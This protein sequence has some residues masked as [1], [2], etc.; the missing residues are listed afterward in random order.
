[1][2]ASP[3]SSD[4]PGRAAL[5]RDLADFLIELSIAL[6][7]HA[8]YP[9][10]HP[11]LAPAAAGVTRRAALLL[12][13][14]STLSLGV[15]RRQLVIEGIATDPK[16]PVLGELAERLHRHH[17]GA[18][19]FRKG[20]EPAE[21][22]DVLKTLAVD[23]ERAGQPLGLGNPERLRAW[24]HV[25]LHSLTYERLE[26]VGEGA[27]AE[28]AR[29]A[30]L[31]VGLARAA[32]ALQPEDDQPMATEPTV[33]A[34]AIDAHE[35]GATAY[36]QVIV[37]YLLQI[38]EELKTAGSAEAMALRRRMS[39]LVRSLKPQTLRRLVEMGG[40]FVQRR[41]FVLD[42]TAGMA[43]DAVLEILKAA[44]DTSQQ[45]I[46]HSLVRLL[47]K[48]AAH[49][50]G[51]SPEIREEADIALRE[52]VQEL[53]RGW[54]LSDPNP[55]VYGTAL[56]RMARANPLFIAP[57]E[58]GYPAEP[59]RVVAMALEV[60][61][62]GPRTLPAVDRVVHEGR[63]PQLLDALAELP[64]TSAA[65]AQVWERIATAEVIGR[66]VATEPVDF[67]V[68]DRLVPRV[69]SSAAA[70]LL[71]AL[72]AAE[73]RGTRRGLL[74]QL[75][76][77]GGGI[78]PIVVARLEDP[79]WYV[80][81]NMLGL[82]DEL[83]ALPEG[84]S[85]ARYTLHADARVRWQA[86]KLQLKLPAERDAALVTALR[87]HEPRIMRLALGLLVALQACP[88][89]LVPL[90]VSH[91]TDRT[92]ASDLRVLAI[93]ALGG[94]SAPAALEALLRLTSAGRTLFGRARFPPKSPE[95]VVAL[96]AL[97]TGWRGDPRAAARL[98]QAAASS[99]PEICA[100][101]RTARALR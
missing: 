4:G 70:P 28:G 21:V 76:R 30:Q 52:Q 71:D 87:D 10:G 45:T 26:L 69:G 90:L 1:M 29:A 74:A 35:R 41:K 23:A 96:Q 57:S 55:G 72:A 97:A 82:L 31:W 8:M 6:H 51:G 78:G 37:G 24:P 98:T 66:V 2:R 25:Q 81:R 68:L 27:P 16:H 36:D 84:F 50:D 95:V 14:R 48:L 11:S 40:D 22:A 39:H 18:V 44:A 85:P 75:A 3:S 61:V 92:L 91:A 86:V 47:S 53:L 94:T 73:S 77:M 17:L 43:V 79:R 5:S 12:E 42:A 93:R 62:V 49:A 7:K 9:E 80:T 88:E 63:L 32:L 19:T 89:V 100:A 38:A 65:A 15:A 13:S 46:S 54:T 20:V 101:A 58:G 99:D 83:P 56:E 64:A 59:D 34:Q 33:I 67:K 60:D